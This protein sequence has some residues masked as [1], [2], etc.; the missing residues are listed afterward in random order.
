MVEWTDE[1]LC[2]FLVAFLRDFFFPGC[3][4]GSGLFFWL[5]AK[6][7]NYGISDRWIGGIGGIGLGSV[8]AQSHREG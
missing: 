2:V 8:D 7:P 1:P 6:G 3:S 4:C 5:D